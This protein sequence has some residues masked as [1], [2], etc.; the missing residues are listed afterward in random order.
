M[1]LASTNLN[2]YHGCLDT[3]TPP[4]SINIKQFFFHNLHLQE[5]IHI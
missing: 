2:K 5:M 3:D 1:S 4:A